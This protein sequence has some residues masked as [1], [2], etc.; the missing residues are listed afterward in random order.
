MTREH[1]QLSRRSFLGVGAKTTLAF[2]AYG[3]LGAR[4]E[5]VLLAESVT[6]GAQKTAAQWQPAF[7]RIDEMIV[8]HMRETGAPGLTLAV[9]NR[10]GTLRVATYGLADIK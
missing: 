6:Q 9:A 7:A 8:A 1:S 5:P 4:F 2:A 10:E 3:A